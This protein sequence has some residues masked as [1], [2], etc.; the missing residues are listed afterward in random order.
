VNFI[1]IT[2]SLLRVT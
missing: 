2:Y 1:S